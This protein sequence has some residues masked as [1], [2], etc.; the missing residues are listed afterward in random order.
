MS[1]VSRA[2][3]A[4]L[5]IAGAACSDL[6]TVP[7]GPQSLAIDSLPFPAVVVGDTLRDTLGI[8]RA[9]SARV[10]DGANRLIPGAPVRFV[11]LDTGVALDSLT[12]RLVGIN[13][14]TSVRLVASV[15]SLQTLAK[16]IGVS[17]RPDTGSN[18]DSLRRLVYV[19]VPRN[20]PANSYSLRVRVGS[21]PLVPGTS[22][23]SVVEGWLV[24]FQ[25]TR[26]P[27]SVVDSTLLTAGVSNS[28]WA[29]TDGSGIA[30]KTLRVVP[31]LGS[32]TN[33]TAVVQ[34]SVTY[35]GAHVRGS[36]VTI[37]VPLAARDSL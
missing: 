31:K 4:T 22:S 2:W 37:V 13:R 9:L 11:A 20:D 30:S 5:L 14:R 32:R 19:T 15:N 23:D 10:Y 16:T 1:H 29:V 21:L 25:L 35:R 27:S 24:K 18:P 36:P 6:T 7:G 28:P 12:G 34:A 3:C 26:L 8:V 33:D 17:N